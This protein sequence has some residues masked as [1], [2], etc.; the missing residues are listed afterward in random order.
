MKTPKDTEAKSKEEKHCIHTDE[1]VCD[2]CKS[3]KDIEISKES[4][5][6]LQEVGPTHCLKCHIDIPLG[7]WGTDTRLKHMQS[8]QKEFTHCGR[9]EDKKCEFSDKDIKN[10]CQSCEDYRGNPPPH[11]CP[12]SKLSPFPQSW[13][14]LEREAFYKEYKDKDIGLFSHPDH[15]IADYWLSRMEKRMSEARE[16]GERMEV[17]MRGEVWERGRLEER[18][19]IKA[20]VEKMKFIEAV[21]PGPNSSRK[22]AMKQYHN[23]ILAKVLS[24]LNQSI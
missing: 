5:N 20:I 15:F 6:F 1:G 22:L 4:V 9:L 10:K 8:C 7:E 18:A 11:V 2:T 14:D 12:N 13:Q 21:F 23:E 19:R 16:E 24:S 3:D 17:Q